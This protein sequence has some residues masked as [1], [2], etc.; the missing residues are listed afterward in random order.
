MAETLQRVLP[1]LHDIMPG[2]GSIALRAFRHPHHVSL[3]VGGSPVTET[4]LQVQEFLVVRLKDIFDVPILAEEGGFSND[5]HELLDAPFFWA[6]DPIDG[7]E[8]YLNGFPYF[9][10]SVGLMEKTSAG[11]VPRLGA[12]FAPALGEYYFS[13]GLAARYRVGGNEHSLS[14]G[15][16]GLVLTN[17]DFTS[18]FAPQ[19]ISASRALRITASTALNI[20]YAGAGYAR[21][22]FFASSVW[23]WA[24]ALAI[25]RP[26]GVMAC[27]Y[28]TLAPKKGWIAEDFKPPPKQWASKSHFIACLPEEAAALKSAYPRK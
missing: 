3:K 8:N 17:Q 27:E 26:L 6:V 10:V 11:H 14:R 13:D 5:G 28:E 22:A 19:D 16:S 24:A 4:D 2:A 18:R 12:V 15:K 7:T 25:A 23:D 1:R 21:G 9:A 20:I